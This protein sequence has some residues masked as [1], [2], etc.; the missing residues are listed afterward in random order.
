M[1]EMN[2]LY[3]GY[4]NEINNV[5]NKLSNIDKKVFDSK[6]RFHVLSKLKFF[7]QYFSL[8]AVVLSGISIARDFSILLTILFLSSTIISTSA[9]GYLFILVNKE[10]ERLA[11]LMK[12]QYNLQKNK[13]ELNILLNQTN[14]IIQ[15]NNKRN[16]DI[17][18]KELENIQENYIENDKTENVSK[19]SR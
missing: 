12:K 11:K 7:S 18:F 2:D 15:K 4:V 17:F 16:S 3:N 10:E 8:A 6:E 14:T 9:T 19:Y 5:N 1:S 13:R